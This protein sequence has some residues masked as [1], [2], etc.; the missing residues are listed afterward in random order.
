ME[1]TSNIPTQ[2]NTPP[3]QPDFFPSPVLP[4]VP[5]PPKQ[6]TNNKKLLFIPI[7]LL[8]IVGLAVIGISLFGKKST[9]KAPSASA[10]SQEAIDGTVQKYF[11]AIGNGKYQEAYSYVDSKD[12]QEAYFVSTG[13]PALA[14]FYNFEGCKIKE[15]SQE[16][17]NATL[18]YCPLKKGGAVLSEYLL[19][20][21]NGTLRIINVKEIRRDKQNNG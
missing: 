19:A 9:P 21:K 12:I 10:P 1:P 2:D 5:E 18:A 16:K 8:V 7:V 13:A 14:G 17:S 11:T 3:P 6:K 15:D 20:E 4:P